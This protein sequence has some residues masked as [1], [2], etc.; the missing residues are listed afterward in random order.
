MPAPS[1]SAAKSEFPWWLAAALVL[2]LAAA[3]F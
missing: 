3:L 2:A 1:A